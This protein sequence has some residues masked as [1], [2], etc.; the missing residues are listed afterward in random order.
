VKTDGV[1]FD[2]LVE[3]FRPMLLNERMRWI[4]KDGQERSRFARCPHLKIEIWGTRLR[5]GAKLIG[6]EQL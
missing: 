5:G 1:S 3:G 2:L 4:G 6:V